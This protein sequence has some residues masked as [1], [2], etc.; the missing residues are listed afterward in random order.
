MRGFL[1]YILTSI[2][3]VVAMDVVAPQVGLGFVGVTQP[4]TEIN[5]PWQTVDRTRKG[6]RLKVPNVNGRE[7]PSGKP[8]MPIG[9]EAA[10]SSLT[11]DAR[12]NFPGRCLAQ[13]IMFVIAQG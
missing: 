4:A 6:D 1:P 2:V 9:C 13:Q 5:Q 8:A 12:V 7:T 3:V 11:S 10:F